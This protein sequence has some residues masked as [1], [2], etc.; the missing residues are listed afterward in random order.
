MRLSRFFLIRLF[1]EQLKVA[2]L[3]KAA[4]HIQVKVEIKVGPHFKLYPLK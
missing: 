2:Q 3:N 1:I 4:K